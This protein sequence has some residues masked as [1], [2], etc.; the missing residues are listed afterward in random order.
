[1]QILDPVQVRVL[2]SLVEKQRTTP[3]VY[4][5]TL[6]ALRLAC[7]QSTNREPVVEYDEPTIREALDR[8]GAIR[9]T[10]VASGPGTRTAKFRHM[11]HDTL[12]LP[13]DEQSLLAV[14]LLRGPQTVA[15]LRTRTERM[16][17]FAS[18]EE[19]EAALGRLAERRLAVLLERRPGQKEQRYAHLL[20][21]T[22][23][24]EALAPHA[25]RPAT[26]GAVGVE[27]RVSALEVEV[28]DLRAA[29]DALRAELGVS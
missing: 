2:G 24:E 14:L 19:A 22:P 1:V 6:N 20:S 28:A 10:R 3:D 16:H 15:E 12:E 8:L 11:L 27:A 13:V 21:G 4:P 25:P 23:T 5:L 7:N 17:P 18:F 9:Y 29:L 26:P